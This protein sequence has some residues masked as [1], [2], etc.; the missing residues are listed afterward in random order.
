[1]FTGIIEA[2]G[3][4]KSLEANGSN[5]SFWV[6]SPLA[7]QLKIDQSLSHNG[8]CLTVEA[9]EGGLY[10][11]TAIEETLVKTN[12]GQLKEGSAVNL[13]RCMQLNGRLDGHIVQG[14]VDSTAVCTAVADKQ[15][16]TEFS[17]RFDEKFATLVIEK[18]SITLNGISLT[19][20][21]VTHTEFTVA[22]IPYT[23][24]HTNM[25][26]LKKDDV[27]NIEFDMIGKYVNRIASLK[28]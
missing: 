18:G 13:E 20:F 1:M 28:K 27:V 7:A 15:G 22:I 3:H 11:V 26:Q 16:S 2:T 4:V 9:I 8:V 24:E 17:F 23:M 10:K 5:I 25:K 19:I 12:L 6:E 21:N 14:H